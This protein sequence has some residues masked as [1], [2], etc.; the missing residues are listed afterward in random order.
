[1]CSIGCDAVKIDDRALN[2]RLADAPGPP[3][4]T[5]KRPQ[6]IHNNILTKRYAK[7]TL[8]QRSRYEHLSYSDSH[9][10]AATIIMFVVVIVALCLDLS[11]AM[12]SEQTFRFC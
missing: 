11:S 6:Q 4:R 12:K 5:L 1:M 2:L 8:L 10:D 7:G 3:F 9:A